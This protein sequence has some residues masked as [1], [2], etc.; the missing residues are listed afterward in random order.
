[1]GELGQ[2]VAGRFAERPQLKVYWDLRL[3]CIENEAV[4]DDRI[5][6]LIS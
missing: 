4:N 1:M 2:T 5:E 6:G 3:I